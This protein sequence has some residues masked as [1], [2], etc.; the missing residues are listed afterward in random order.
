VADASEIS[1]APS[2]ENEPTLVLREIADALGH[3]PVIDG[4]AVEIAST[5]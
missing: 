2:P 5:A 3:L 4:I 1:R